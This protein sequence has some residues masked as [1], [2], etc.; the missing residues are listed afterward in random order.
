MDSKKIIIRLNNSTTSIDVESI[1]G[2]PGA[3]GRVPRDA[4][5]RKTMKTL[6]CYIKN[7][8]RS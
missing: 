8:L 1:P 5:H 3:S 4:R 6:F 2:V 7:D